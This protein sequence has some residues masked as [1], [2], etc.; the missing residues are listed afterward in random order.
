MDLSV[1]QRGFLE[2]LSQTEHLSA[3]KL[4]TYQL[5]LL[6]PLV[7]HATANVPFYRDRLQSVF[8]D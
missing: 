1:R 8:A 4:Q 3:E 7:R 2:A 5:G 6:E